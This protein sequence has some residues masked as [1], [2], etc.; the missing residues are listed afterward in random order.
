MK[1]T[2]LWVSMLCVA[3]VCNAQAIELISNLPGND[4]SQS[5]SLGTLRNKGMGF[6]MPD[7]A[8]SLVGVTLRLETYGANTVPIVEI[9]SDVG[10]VPGVSLITL[11]N[12]SFAP[13]GIANYD[14]APSAPLTL[15]AN[16][17]Y[18]I[19]AYGQ[20]GATPY[21]WKASSPAVTPTGLATHAGATW[22]TGGPPPTGTSSIVCSYAV[23]GEGVVSIESESWASI[24]AMYR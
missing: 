18:W 9:W 13:S 14:F 22:G 20:A 19:V 21:D 3:L 17:T 24:K 6:T 1:K 15:L 5:A 2:I 16:T 11:I 23:N 10:G 8:Y 7:D 12:P 4:G